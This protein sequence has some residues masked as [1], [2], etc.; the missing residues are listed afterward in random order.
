MISN[1]GFTAVDK[2]A[3]LSSPARSMWQNMMHKVKVEKHPLH[4]TTTVAEVQ[5]N[6]VDELKPNSIRAADDDTIH[7][8]DS[9]VWNNTTQTGYCQNG[10][11]GSSTSSDMVEVKNNSRS[12]KNK[13][14][15][16]QQIVPA[17]VQRLMLCDSCSHHAPSQQS[18]PHSTPHH[19]HY[20]PSLQNCI[21]LNEQWDDEATLHGKSTATR[22][23]T[24]NRHLHQHS[25]GF[26]SIDGEVRNKQQHEVYNGYHPHQYDGDPCQSMY[27]VHSSFDD[28]GSFNGGPSSS[29]NKYHVMH[30]N[31]HYH[32]K[33]NGYIVTPIDHNNP[34]CQNC[35]N[36]GHHR[37]QRPPSQQQPMSSAVLD[38]STKSL[39]TS[40]AS[41][42]DEDDSSI[43]LK[44]AHL[45]SNPPSSAKPL[46]H[47]HQT[48]AS[49]SHRGGESSRHSPFFVV[50]N[51]VSSDDYSDVSSCLHI[52]PYTKSESGSTLCCTVAT[53]NRHN[54]SIGGGPQ[55]EKIPMTILDHNECIQNAPSA[56]V[57]TEPLKSGSMPSLMYPNVRST[58]KHS[59][60]GITARRKWNAKCKSTRKKKKSGGSRK[61]RKLSVR[62]RTSALS[63]YY[64]D[65]ASLK[66]NALGVSLVSS[67][68]LFIIHLYTLL[69]YPDWKESNTVKIMP[70]QTL[71]SQQ[72]LIY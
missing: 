33:S 12:I 1:T 25:S 65:H 30:N 59:L 57:V 29:F 45:K 63:S 70:S 64:R 28:Y 51:P 11:E 62:T 21:R 6:F 10:V 58:N 15:Q 50:T 26:E 14:I 39:I 5:C 17:A 9:K 46:H 53:A 55:L 31:I 8:V 23:Q 20:H 54:T 38:N 32:H 71:L 37:H 22:L 34:T 24:V 68:R 60:K 66:K 48:F 67:V 47:H 4:L 41:I 43:E 36:D 56:A 27:K 72:I 16:Q 52:K 3:T 42:Y 49:P 61:S 18:A 44:Q 7:S 69:K 40:S 19:H 35:T 2:N 13:S